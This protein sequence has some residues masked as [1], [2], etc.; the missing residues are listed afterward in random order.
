VLPSSYEGQVCSI[1]GALEIVGERWSLLIVRNIFLGLRRFEELQA[2]LG[3]ARNILQTRL[4]RL[5]QEGVLERRLYSERPPRYEYRLT[6]KGLDLWPT[7]VALMQWGDRHA[8]PPAGAPVL[9]EHR[10][11][12][13]RVD[14]HR[15]CARCGARLTARD[16]VGRPG[17]GAPPDHPLRRRAAAAT[18]HVAATPAPAATSSP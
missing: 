11:C 14:E 4:R 17:P 2:N 5:V 15:T 10:G 16:A 12:G 7:I 13:G 18:P 1:A 8:P 6:E 3:I 9:I